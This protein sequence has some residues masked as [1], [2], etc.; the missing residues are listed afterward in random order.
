MTKKCRVLSNLTP[1]AAQ[2][3]ARLARGEKVTEIADDWGVSPS[4]VS[5]LAART[6]VALGAR[7]NR[8]AMV[9]YAR[10]GYKP[11]ASA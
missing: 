10:N 8:E 3:M 5:R 2:L 9:K 11:E 4:T 7:T 1:D 6:R